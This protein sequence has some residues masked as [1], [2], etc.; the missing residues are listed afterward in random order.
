[1]TFLI[2]LYP[3]MRPKFPIGYLGYHQTH[4]SVLHFSRLHTTVLRPYCLSVLSLVRQSQVVIAGKLG[5]KSG[6]VQTRTHSVQRHRL[7][8]VESPNAAIMKPRCSASTIT[9]LTLPWRRQN[10]PTACSPSIVPI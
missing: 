9:L 6:T 5:T 2:N 1:M 3:A 10:K 4:G 8:R 7:T